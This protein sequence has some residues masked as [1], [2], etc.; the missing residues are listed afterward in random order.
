MRTLEAIVF[1]QKCVS[2]DFSVSIRIV[3]GELCLRQWTMLPIVHEDF[4]N[5]PYVVELKHMFCKDNKIKR[6]SQCCLLLSFLEIK[7]EDCLQFFLTV[8]FSIFLLIIQCKNKPQKWNR[9][10]SYDAEDALLIGG[11]KFSAKVHVLSGFQ[12]KRCH[13]TI[14]FP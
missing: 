8:I 2:N 5:R 6:F 3:I 11:I 14:A 10:L 4:R 13:A 1:I 7:T 12:W 9:W